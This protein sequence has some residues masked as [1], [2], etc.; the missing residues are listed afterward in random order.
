MGSTFKERCESRW[1]KYY[2]LCD[3]LNETLAFWLYTSVS[4]TLV[5]VR[6]TLKAIHAPYA[7]EWGFKIWKT[8]LDHDKCIKVINTFYQNTLFGFPRPQSSLTGELL[9][10][11]DIITMNFYNL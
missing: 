4:V 6:L 5:N 7:E 2:S 11:H 9:N 10:I 1:W 3:G 8:E